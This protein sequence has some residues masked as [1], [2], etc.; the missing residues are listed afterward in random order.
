MLTLLLSSPN[1]ARTGDKYLGGRMEVTAGAAG[2]G[3]G[4]KDTR[5]KK[6]VVEGFFVSC[7]VSNVYFVTVLRI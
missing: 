2:A 1:S 5:C 7:L 3:A 6:I 4:D